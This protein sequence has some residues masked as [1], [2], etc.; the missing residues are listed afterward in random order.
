MD[1]TGSVNRMRFDML[2]GSAYGKVV[3]DV[4]KALGEAG[5]RR[6]RWTR[7]CWLVAVQG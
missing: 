7:L 3:A 4:E 1:F 2:A 5:G 6:V